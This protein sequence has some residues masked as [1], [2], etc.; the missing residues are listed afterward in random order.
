MR[1]KEM[2]LLSI[3]YE[4]LRVYLVE[5]LGVLIRSERTGY[6]AIYIDTLNFDLRW[7]K[8]SMLSAFMALLRRSL[9]L[10]FSYFS[11]FNDNIISRHRTYGIW[12]KLV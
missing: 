5:Y 6:T 12:T 2:P 9:S 1:L 8:R 11:L 10:G 4:S 3:L 7:A